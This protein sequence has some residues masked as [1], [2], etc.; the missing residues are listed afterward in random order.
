MDNGALPAE[1]MRLAYDGQ[2]EIKW[3]KI[4]VRPH[5][6]MN[7]LSTYIINGQ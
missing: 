3:L 6:S 2:G 5:W 1:E 4:E 7:V